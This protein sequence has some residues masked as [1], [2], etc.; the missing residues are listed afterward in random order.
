[1]TLPR[2]DRTPIE[3]PKFSSATIRFGPHPC[4]VCGALATGE[5]LCE[6]CRGENGQTPPEESSADAA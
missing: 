2:S 6:E 4:P 1:M 3:R 5:L